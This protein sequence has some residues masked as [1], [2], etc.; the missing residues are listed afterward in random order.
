MFKH[1]IT[2]R[3]WSLVGTKLYLILLI[4][5]LALTAYDYYQ[6]HKDFNATFQDYIAQN[7]LGEE[8]IP[9]DGYVFTGEGMVV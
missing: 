6:V 4:V 3:F 9:T 1:R 7:F 5:S 8:R 2:K